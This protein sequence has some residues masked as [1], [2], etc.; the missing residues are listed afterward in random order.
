[1]LF[2]TLSSDW[3]AEN[4]PLLP[5]W[6]ILITGGSSGLGF[7]A[8]AELLRKGA[9]VFLLSEDM[10]EGTKYEQEP[11]HA[12]QRTHAS[13]GPF[14]SSRRRLLTTARSNSSRSTSPTSTP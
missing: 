14:N 3:T 9:H 8:A 10:E 1:M 13:P 11:P 7:A 6:K 5:T 2:G 12:S 4:I